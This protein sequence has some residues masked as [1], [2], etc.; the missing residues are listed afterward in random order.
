MRTCPRCHASMIVDYTAPEDGYTPVWKCLGCGRS[1]LLDGERQAEDDRNRRR[2]VRSI[3][4]DS[5]IGAH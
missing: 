1:L 5:R 4:E 3:S 2:I